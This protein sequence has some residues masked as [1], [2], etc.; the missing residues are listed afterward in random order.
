[1]T[2]ILK[3][4]NLDLK[5]VLDIQ[6]KSQDC[7]KDDIL[8]YKIN[9]LDTHSQD[10]FE[11][12]VAKAS[13]KKCLV[14]KSINSTFEVTVVEE[15]DWLKLQKEI[16]DILYPFSNMK[17]VCVTGTNGKTTT[18][19]LIRQCAVDLN[20]NILTI[21]TL[22]VYK[23]TKLLE[24]FG[25]TSPNYI[26]FRKVIHKYASDIDLLAVEL[27]SHALVQERYYRF[28]FDLGI[29]TNF[30]QDHLDYHKTMDE[31][32]TAKAKVFDVVDEV[33]LILG[34]E[35]NILNQAQSDK[36]KKVKTITN[37]ESEFLQI[38]YNKKNLSLA[39]ECLN[40]FRY[41]VE[42]INVN[43][44]I[45]P[46]GRY[47]VTAYGSGFV[48]V[49]FAHTPDALENICKEIRKT[50]KDKKLITIFGCGGN[51]DKEKRPLMAK[52]ASLYSHFL[53]ITSD[54]PRNES[55]DV[56]IGDIEK[57]ADV[58]YQ[59]ILDRKQAIVKAM[60]NW[61][62]EIILI[63]GKGHE[64]YIESNGIKIPYSDQAVIDEVINAEI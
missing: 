15:D 45:A 52:K 12:R 14:N 20:L 30:S 6:W 1:M 42:N 57:G 5:E 59:T 9:K 60:K 55:P 25:L 37:L 31:Y 3:K 56:I 40:H 32:F 35:T 16:C 43:E 24:N 22:G 47:N 28:T 11:K 48:I 39:L 17:S 38:E 34:S 44:L 27:S 8:F 63:A 19:D 10:L 33:V 26:D 49:D 23:N 54:N 51:R 18:V 4:Y 62:N 2:N 58:N 53:Y 13:Y 36:I 46:P 61:K 7:T 64:N 50:Y 29:W 21:G 41:D